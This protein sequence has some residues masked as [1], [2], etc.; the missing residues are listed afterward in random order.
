MSIHDK[1]KAALS[2]VRPLVDGKAS[3][4]AAILFTSGLKAPR[5]GCPLARQPARQCRTGIRA[6]RL[7][8]AGQGVQ[9][10]SGVS[11]VRAHR[12]LVL[13]AYLRRS[14][15]PL[16]LATT[17]HRIVPELI[18]GSNATILFG[19]DTFLAGY[20]RSA[21]PYDLRSV[22]LAFLAGAEPVKES[23]RQV[24][25][26]KFALRIS[27]GYGVT[28]TA[29]VLAINT[30]SYNRLDGRAHHAGHEARLEPV[31]ECRTA[32]ASTS[33]DPM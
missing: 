22:L 33:A 20:A 9:R 27:E 1:L 15:L 8:S 24:F 19:T 6:H 10:P 21:H 31:P 5:R 12:R 7:R 11:L 30:P 14:G 25:V 16:S 29:P 4:R 2:Y 3:E 17:A 28:E 18:Y 23:T 26:E 13:L 32:V